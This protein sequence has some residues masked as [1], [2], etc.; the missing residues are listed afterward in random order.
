MSHS[1]VTEISLKTP[2]KLTLEYGLVFIQADEMLEVTPNHIRLRKILLTNTQ[3]QWAK[4]KNLSSL[5]KKE[6]GIT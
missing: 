6:M 1:Q 3:R 2:I 5:A 4:R